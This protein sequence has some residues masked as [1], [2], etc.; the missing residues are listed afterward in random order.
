[1]LKINSEVLN[2]FAKEG[3]TINEGIAIDA[4]LVKSASRPISNNE[5]EKR[6]KRSKNPEGKVDK[7]GNP[8]KFSRDL[9]SDWVVQNDIPHWG[10]KE[11]ASVDVDNGFIL[12]T[13]L[14][15]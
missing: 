3:L 9:E 2:Q 12:A 8:L 13:T 6:R 4:R 5:I 7:N 15:P 10:L 1:M 11:H 14:T